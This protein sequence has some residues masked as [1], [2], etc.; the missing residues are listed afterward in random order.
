MVT[1]KFA[2]EIS[3]FIML[4]DLERRHVC[5]NSHVLICN[6]YYVNV[7]MWKDLWIGHLWSWYCDPAVQFPPIHLQMFESRFGMC[8][9]QSSF[10]CATSFWTCWEIQFQDVD[11]STPRLHSC[12]SALILL[13]PALLA[14]VPDGAAAE[15][16]LR[17]GCRKLAPPWEGQIIVNHIE[18]WGM[19]TGK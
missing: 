7:D 3:L 18:P 16:G 19:N 13:N 1:P 10:H 11:I 14:Q 15:R 8:T 9:Y 4:R 12:C 6:V 5:C 2:Q 17:D